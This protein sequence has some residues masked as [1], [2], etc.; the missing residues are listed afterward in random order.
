MAVAD[1]ILAL[2]ILVLIAMIAVW[3]IHL[4]ASLDFKRRLYS[5]RDRWFHGHGH[6]Y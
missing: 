2:E 4:W 6:T 1:T 5:F 3:C